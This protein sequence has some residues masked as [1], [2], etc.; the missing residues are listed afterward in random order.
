MLDLHCHLLPG[1]DDGAT[2]LDQAAAMC[3]C[4]V[5]CGFTVAAPSPHNGEGPGGD[6]SPTDAAAACTALRDRLAADGISLD[7]HPNAEHHVSMMLFE[8]IDA[9]AVV[10]IGGSGNWL[11][12]E[13]PFHPIQAEEILFRLQ[14]KGYRLLLAHP[15]RHPYLEVDLLARLVA[16]GIK[17]QLEVG[18]FLNLYGKQAHFRA[19]NMLDQGLVHVLATDIHS[20]ADATAWIN[21]GLRAVADRYG[22]RAV[23][24]GTDENPRALLADAGDQIRAITE[25]R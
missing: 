15:E 1:V 5:D 16:R 21:G 2:D 25:A 4:L 18:S 8:R 22:K 11:L 23:A 14:T 10:P 17:M 19:L 9:G 12:V 13:L 20:P 6:V 3:R 24:I 7:L